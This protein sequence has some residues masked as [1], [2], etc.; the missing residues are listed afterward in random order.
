M[1]A[2][3]GSSSMELASISST[4]SPTTTTESVEE[5]SAKLASYQKFMADY[6]VKASEQKFQ[7][8]KVAEMALAKKYE[9]KLLLLNGSNSESVSPPVVST[10]AKSNP[11]FEKRN[12]KVAAAAGKSRWG[13]KEVE[14]AQVAATTTTTTAPPAEKVIDVVDIPSEVIEADHG[15]RAD[16]GVGGLTLAERVMLGSQ[17]STN[18]EIAHTVKNTSNYEKRNAYLLKSANA[19]KSRWG[20]AEIAN[21]QR[22]EEQKALSGSNTSSK[23]LVA[24]IDVKDADY[25]LRADGGVGGPSL[26][27]RVNLGAA[28]MQSA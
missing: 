3:G 18:V 5:L 12:A 2:N 16:G 7:A 4:Q 11:A 9:A 6:I 14:K 23:T 25:G 19:G 20:D 26:S 17:A 8:V 1:K 13:E 27:E 10:G 28:L 24:P 15:L 21:V 22:F